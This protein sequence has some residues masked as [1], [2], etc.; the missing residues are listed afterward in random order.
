MALK[1]WMAR[2]YW[3]CR[4]ARSAWNRCSLQTPDAGINV[5][6]IIQATHEGTS[7]DIT[8]TV[9]EQDLALARDVS[10]SVLDA[11][12]GELSTEAGLTKLSIRGA[13][14]MGRPGIAAS[15]FNCLCQQG[16]NLRLIAPAK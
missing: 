9:N 6:L 11:L 4:S 16:I 10:Q 1:R 5:D 3:P 12:G 14:I 2:P 13:G 15:L 8:F 7:N